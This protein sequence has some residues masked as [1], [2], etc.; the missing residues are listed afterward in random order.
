MT[1]EK[2][3]QCDLLKMDCEG[4][5]YAILEHTSRHVL[6][7]FKRIMLEFHLFHPGH[8]LR[9][10]EHCLEECGFSFQVKKKW[11]HHLL[12]RTGMIWA[13]RID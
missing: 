3:D 11:L 6:R 12:N 5:E 4:G 10:I 9:R 1:S 7:R 13:T 2:L 8:S